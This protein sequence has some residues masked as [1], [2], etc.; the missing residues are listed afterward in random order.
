MVYAMIALILLITIIISVVSI[1]NGKK[2]NPLIVLVAVT[3]GMI[4]IFHFINKL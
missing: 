2:F 1:K 4:V 3:M